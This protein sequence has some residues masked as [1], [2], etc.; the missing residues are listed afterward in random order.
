MQK[1]Q[2]TLTKSGTKTTVSMAFPPLPP[3]P[4]APPP[5]TIPQFQFQSLTTPPVQPLTYSTLTQVQPPAFQ[6][7]PVTPVVTTPL[8]LSSSPM[9]LSMDNTSIAP[10]TTTTTAVTA[11]SNPSNEYE[12]HLQSLFNQPKS[13]TSSNSTTTK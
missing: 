3:P 13:N 4:L 8:H 12:K 5:L 10:T 11:N 7:F 1:T 9:A 2:H 6:Q